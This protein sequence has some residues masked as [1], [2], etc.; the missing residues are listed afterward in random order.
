MLTR[1][2]VLSVDEFRYIA[3]VTYPIDILGQIDLQGKVLSNELQYPY[4]ALNHIVNG[5][6][7]NPYFRAIMN[8][9]RPCSI[10]PATACGHLKEDGHCGSYEARPRTCHEFRCGC[11][12]VTAKQNV[13]P[14]KTGI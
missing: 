13:I 8:E 5:L 14:V 2:N 9:D 1:I 12:I 3:E 11:D 10:T 6:L 4:L 7:N